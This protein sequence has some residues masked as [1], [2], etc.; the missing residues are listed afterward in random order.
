MA[1]SG[2]V[3]ESLTILDRYVKLMGMA[4]TIGGVI[5]V[6]RTYLGAWS[7]ARVVNL[8]LMD[9][10]W[11]PFDDDQRPSPFEDAEDVFR[12]GASIHDQCTALRTA[13][14]SLTPELLELDL[15]FFFAKESIEVHL[16][17]SANW[18]SPSAGM[19]HKLATS[20]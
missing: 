20:Q 10:G 11:A 8:Q 19:P 3:C 18:R 15:F 9:A 14:L 1:S 16:S 6:V 2:D 5:E 17:E 13:G 12:V 4:A 7:S